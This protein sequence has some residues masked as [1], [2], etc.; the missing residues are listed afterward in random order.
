[1]RYALDTNT[2]IYFF[3]GMGRINDN[4]LAHAPGDILIPAVVLYEI[5]TGLAKSNSPLKRRKQLSAL[6]LD[7]SYQ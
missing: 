5:E 4:L 2:L 3:K 6:L 1:M 7:I